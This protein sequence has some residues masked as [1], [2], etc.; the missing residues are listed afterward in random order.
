MR[1]AALGAAVVIAI[2]GLLSAV[3]NLWLDEAF[4]VHT[5][6]AGPL[7]AWNQAIAFE[8]Q[9]PLYF[10]LE[11]MWRTLNETSPVFARFPSVIFAAAAVA[12]IVAAASR[13]APRVPPGIVALT[14]AFN[15][16]V[17]WAATEMRVHA[18]VL[19]IGA[20]LSWTFYEGFVYVL[21]SRRAQIC[22]IVIAIIGLYTQYYVGVLLAAQCIALFVMRRREIGAFVA[23]QGVVAAVFLPFAGVALM[24]VRSSADFVTRASVL[25]AVHDVANAAFVF[26][27]PHDLNWAGGAKLTGFFLAAALLLQ[28]W[29]IG[30]PVISRSPARTLVVQWLAGL[31]M[32]SL[33]FGTAGTP[34]DVVRHLVVLLPSSLL[35]ALLLLSSFTRER[36]LASTLAI[37]AFAVFAYTQ[38]LS[39]YRAPLVKAGDWES[40][41]AVLQKGDRTIPVAVFPAELALPLSLY[42]P[43]ATIPVPK[44]MPFSTDYVRATTL[45][46]ESEVAD[47]LDPFSIRSGRLWVVTDGECREGQLDS[48]DYHCHFLEAY[49]YGRYRLVAHFRFRGAL[50]RLYARNPNDTP[51]SMI[52]RDTR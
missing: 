6:G 29:W 17:I 16:I 37:T 11:S 43:I 13:I 14:T 9:P 35:V 20:A 18:L 32:F 33:V 1:A 28:L 27:F 3:L 10:V 38:L 44:P 34:V 36:V 47:L 8:G 5:T 41:A 40:V 46:G 26:V 21:P 12:V 50:A 4:T 2:G 25:H 7:T 24:Q 30:R 31:A 48:Y 19:L 52:V 51:I 23:A 15:P 42:L 22:Y 39:Q 49:L 45:R